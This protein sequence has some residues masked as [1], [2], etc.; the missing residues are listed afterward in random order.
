MPGQETNGTQ[1]NDVTLY[2]VP[3]IANEELCVCVCVY[4]HETSLQGLGTTVS[5]PQTT[6]WE[7]TKSGYRTFCVFRLCL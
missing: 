7:E 1:S 6:M 4:S 3:S 2:E 5:P